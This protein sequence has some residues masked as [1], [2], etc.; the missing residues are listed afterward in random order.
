MERLPLATE[1]TYDLAVI[2]GGPAGYTCAIRADTTLWCWGE[3]YDGQLGVRRTTEIFRPRQVTTP[4]ADGWASLA[5]VGL[6]RRHPQP[7]TTQL[8]GGGRILGCD[9]GANLPA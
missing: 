9:H 3:D 5:V 8:F 4:A 2:G 7:G 1:T 6:P